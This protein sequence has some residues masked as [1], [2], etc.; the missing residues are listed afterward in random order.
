MGHA[1]MLLF[2]ALI[3][4][5]FTLGDLAAPHIA[6]S[7]L[8]AARFALAAG[9]LIALGFGVLGLLAGRFLLLLAVF[10]SLVLALVPSGKFIA[11]LSQDGLEVWAIF[12]EMIR[13]STVQVS[14]ES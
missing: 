4:V 10:P 14:L 1:A 8:T 11:V 7:A 13:I 9:G 6:P 12:P 3:S 5:S 2:A